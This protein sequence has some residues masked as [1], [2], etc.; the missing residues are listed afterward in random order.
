MG[1][2]VAGLDPGVIGRGV[3]DRADDLQCPRFIPLDLNA[4]AAELAL[5]RSVEIVRGRR[6]DHAGERVQFAQRAVHKLTDKD[7]FWDIH[8]A[9]VGGANLSHHFA[10]RIG[11]VGF[12]RRNASDRVINRPDECTPLGRV[13]QGWKR[14][15]NARRGYQRAKA[16]HSAGDQRPIACFP[17][18]VLAGILNRSPEHLVLNALEI[19]APVDLGVGRLIVRRAGC[20]PARGSTRRLQIGRNQ[21]SVDRFFF[22][23]ALLLHRQHQIWRIHHLDPQEPARGL[24]A[25]LP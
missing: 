21:Q 22:G 16:I 11:I 1:D 8:S 3:F 15:A 6:P 18:V 19:V 25:T 4:H 23:S 2:H 10:K 14:A 12:H 13:V 17:I 24:Q 7:G 5:G 9:A 20:R